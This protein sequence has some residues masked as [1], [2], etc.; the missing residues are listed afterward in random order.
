[1]I[2]ENTIKEAMSKLS[3]EPDENGLLPM[4]DVY[5]TRLFADYYNKV[6]NA[7]MDEFRKESNDPEVLTAARNLLIEAAHLCGFNTFGGIVQSQEWE[8]I[9]MPMIESREDWIYGMVAIINSIFGWGEWKITELIPNEKLVLRVE[10]GFEC[11]YYLRTRGVTAKDGQCYLTAGTTAA[12]MNLVY[13]GE[14][15]N[16]PNLDEEFYQ[17]LFHFENGFYTMETKCRCKGDE[18]CE[19]L[20]KRR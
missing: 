11:D 14:I 8:S 2:D 19:F 10:N 3:L 15:E 6:C 4:F 16:M 5:L 9:V 12:L 18:Y 1:M 17:K 20:V 7:F 13:Y